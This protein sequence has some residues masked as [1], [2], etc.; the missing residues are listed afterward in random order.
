M[1]HERIHRAISDDGT[2]IAGRVLGQGPP[3]VLVHGGLGSGE[4]SWRFLLPY[5]TERFTCFTMSTRGR[6]L[7]ADSPDHTVERL[8]QDVTSFV[9]SIGDPVGL[10]GHSSG[11]AL[12]LAATARSSAVSSLAVYEPATMELASEDLVTRFENARADIQRATDEGRLV[13][14]A[15]IMFEEIALANDDE[16]AAISAVG[17]AKLMAPGVPEFLSDAKPILTWRHFDSA[18]LGRITVPTL[19]LRGSRTDAFYAGV[20]DHLAPRL[21][22]ARVREIP[23]AG[24][25]G[26][27][28]AAESVAEELMLF[29]VAA[30]APA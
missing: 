29:L 23:G 10:V 26:P 25:L 5:L 30:V 24:H 15:R 2:Q 14:G 7:S 28:L 12:S 17:T 19:L 20:V 6:G 27:Q 11:G 3:L 21:A 4:V 9:A 16:L 13:D 18:L 22:D 1:E 8:V